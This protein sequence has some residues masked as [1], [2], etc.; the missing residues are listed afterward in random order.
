M[1][2]GDKALYTIKFGKAETLVTVTPALQCVLFVECVLIS[3]FSPPLEMYVRMHACVYACMYA[4]TCWE[5]AE[6]AEY[7]HRSCVLS[8]TRTIMYM[9]LCMYV[10]LRIYSMHACTDMLRETWHLATNTRSHALTQVTWASYSECAHHLSAM[11]MSAIDAA[12]S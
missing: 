3:Y 7:D 11:M 8:L 2:A 9:Y 5:A 1:Y 12:T 6:A 10:Y 4:H